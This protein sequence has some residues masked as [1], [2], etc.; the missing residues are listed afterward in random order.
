MVRSMEWSGVARALQENAE[1]LKHRDAKGRNWL[2][3]CCGGDLDGDQR[4]AA[5]SLKTAEVLVDAGLSIHQEAFTEGRWKATPLWFAIARGRNLLLAEYLLKRGSN[6]NYCLWAAAFN[7]DIPAI[8]LLVAHG[9]DVNDSS[10]DDLVEN[11]SPFLGAIKWSHF[12]AAEELLKLGADVNYQDRKGMTALHYMLK[13]GSDKR[14]FP[15]LI[16]HGARGDL[17][18]SQGVCAAELM[19]KKRDADFRK[20]AEQLATSPRRTA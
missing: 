2:H 7:R 3:L 15:M 8:R 12:E 19:R 9:A 4:K 11:E 16:A 18:N 14:F 6:P 10:V 17:R 5:D 20:M 1:L 13:K